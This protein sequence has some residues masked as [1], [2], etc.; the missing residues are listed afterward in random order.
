MNGV[1]MQSNRQ[2]TYRQATARALL[3]VL[4]TYNFG[5]E[6]PLGQLVE[7]TGLDAEKLHGVLLGNKDD[8]EIMF[9]PFN[10]TWCKQGEPWETYVSSGRIKMSQDPRAVSRLCDAVASYPRGIRF[11]PSDLSSV[12]GYT[13]ESIGAYFATLHLHDL[14]GLENLGIVRDYSVKKQTFIK[15]R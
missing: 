3:P 8:W 10:K 7:S 6:L 15:V 14:N 4:P 11:T 1:T 2:H 5:D 13:E 9:D 12:T